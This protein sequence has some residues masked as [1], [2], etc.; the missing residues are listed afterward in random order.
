[1]KSAIYRNYQIF[2]LTGESDG[3][4]EK[5]DSFIKENLSDL[6]VYVFDGY[7]DLLFYGKDKDNIIF[8]F[9]LKKE[10][11]YYHSRKIHFVF[12]SDF[13]INNRDINSFIRSYVENTLNIKAVGIGR[14]VSIPPPSEL[15]KIL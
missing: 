10:H 14:G 5:I 15:K 12:K 4:S 9:D 7:N 6:N 3:L 2:K 8:N 13:N 11:F 1:M